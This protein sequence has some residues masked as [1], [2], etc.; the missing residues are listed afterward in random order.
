[1]TGW[2]LLKATTGTPFQTVPDGGSAIALLGIALIGLE[3]LR[4]KLRTA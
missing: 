2:T 4:R 3:A 1:M